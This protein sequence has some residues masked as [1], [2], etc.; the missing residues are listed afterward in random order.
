MN[1]TPEA[2]RHPHQELE[3][4]I[5]EIKAFGNALND[6]VIVTPLIDVVSRI[7]D[8]PEDLTE[9][10]PKDIARIQRE[11][12]DCKRILD[13]FGYEYMKRIITHP[14]QSRVFKILNQANLFE[15]EIR[16]SVGKKI[17]LEDGQTIVMTKELAEALTKYRFSIG[18]PPVTPK[19]IET[20]EQILF[21]GNLQSIYQFRELLG[22][23]KK[24]KA[25]FDA[26]IANV[27]KTVVQSTHYTTADEKRQ[28]EKKATDFNN[29]EGLRGLKKSVV[30]GTA[31]TAIRLIKDE[32][33]SRHSNG[34]HP[35]KVIDQIDKLDDA[36]IA[37]MKKD[38]ET[39]FV[40]KISKV[41]HHIFTSD[42][43]EDKWRGVLGRLILVDDSGNSRRAGTT[44]VYSLNP[45]ITETLDKLHVKD[46]G[47]PANTQMNLRSIIE[48]FSPQG[49]EKLEEKV[50]AKIDDYEKSGALDAPVDELRKKEWFITSQR[51]Y[52]SLTNF[53]RFLQ[54]VKGIKTST[55]GEVLEQSQDLAREIEA[56]AMDYFFKDLKGGKYEVVSVPQGGGRKEIGHV[57]QFQLRKFEAKLADFQSTKLSDLKV[58]LAQL[59]EQR[60]ITASD[61]EAHALQRARLQSRSPLSSIRDAESGSGAMDELKEHL[62]VLKRRGIQEAADVLS[63]LDEALGDA[64]AANLSGQVRALI[65]GKLDGKG[66]GSFAKRM[67]RGRPKAL[68]A[69]VRKGLGL[70]KRAVGNVADGIEEK[71]EA[72]EL[73]TEATDLSFAEKLIND[74]E[75]GSMKPHLALAEVGWTF[76]DVLK[77]DDFPR[78]NYIKIKLKENGEMDADS[79]EE[80]FESARK[81][82]SDFPELF[83]FYCASTTLVINDPHNPTSKVAKNSTKLRLLDIASKYGLTI[84]SDEAYHKQV[85]KSI[86]DEQGDMSLCEFY[87]LNRPRFPKPINIYTTLPTTKWA[88]GGGRRTGVVVTNDKSVSGGE[89]FTEF[90]K[91]N[92]D[93]YNNMS[94]YLDRETYT[95]GIKVKSVCKQLETVLDSASLFLASLMPS[96][97]GLDSSEVIDKIFTEEFA[98]FISTIP[99]LGGPNASEII[100][101]ILSEEFSNISERGFC[102]PLYFALIEARNELDRLQIRGASQLEIVKYISDFISNVKNFRL[103]KQ[104]QRDSAKRSNAANDAIERVAQDYPFLSDK[105]IKPE[106]PFYV[107]V[108]LDDGGADPSLTPFLEAV[109]RARKIDVVPTENGYVRFAFGGEVDG[110]KEGYE[111]LSLAIETDLRI[112]LKYWQQFKEERKRLNQEKDS[113]PELTALKKLFPGGEIELARTLRDKK[114]L[115]DKLAKSKSKGRKKLV[116]DRPANL[117]EIIASIEPDSPAHIVTLNSV[118]CKTPQAMVESPVFRDL[119]NYYLLQIKSKIPELMFLEDNDLVAFYGARQFAQKFQTRIFKNAERE[120]YAKIAYEIAR[121]WFSDSTIKILASEEEDSS[122][123]AIRGSESDLSDYIKAFLKAFLSTED[124]QKLLQSFRK[125]PD[126]KELKPEVREY[127]PIEIGYPSTFQAG[128]KA[129]HGV[130][131]DQSLPKWLQMSINKGEFVANSTATDPSPMLS[132]SGT[133]RVPGV[134]RAILRRDGDGENAPQAEFF[135]GNLEKFAEVMDPKDFVY[136]MVQIGGTKVLLVMSRAYSHY[137]VEELRLFPQTDL[138]PE[139]VANCK[140]DAV[141][142]LGLPTKVMGE[143]YRIGYFMDKNAAG[144]NIPVSWVDTESITDYMGY[145]KK[146]ILTVANEKVKEREMMPIHGSAFT[147]I[148]K[149]GLR[150]TMVMAGD[151]GTGKSETI[152]AMIEQIIKNEGYADQLEGIEFL[153]GDMLSLFEGEDHQL[154]MLGTEQGDFMRMTDIPEDWKERFRDR[155]ANGS[156][157]NLSDPT[158]PRITIGN[159]CDPTKFQ[160]PVRVNAFLNINNFEVPPLSSM[161]ETE[162]PH[163]LLLQEYV[164]GYRGEKG[165]SGDQPNIYASVLKSKK[166]GSQEVLGEYKRDLDLLLGWDILTGASGKAENAYLNFNDVPGGVFRAKSMVKDLFEGKN[167]AM[168]RKVESLTV[169]GTDVKIVYKNGDKEEYSIPSDEPLTLKKS[170]EDAKKGKVSL[171]LTNESGAE[172]GVDI[173]TR[174]PVSIAK[175]TYDVRENHFYAIVKDESGKEEKVIIDREGVFNKIY[176]PIASTYCGNPFV[177]PEGMA[178]VL[179]RFAEVMEKA[180]VITGTLYT[181]LKVAGMEF[182]GPAKASQDLIK[183]LMTDERVNKRFLG[184][185]KK[186]DEA[187]R[188][189]YGAAVLST[190]TIPEAIMAHNLFLIERHESDNVRPVDSKGKVINLKTPHYQCKENIERKAF[191]PSLITPEIAGIISDVCNDPQNDTFSLGDFE[192][193]LDRYAHIQAY[194]SKEELIYQILISNGPAQLNYKETNIAQIPKKEVKKAQKIAEAMMQEDQEKAEK[195]KVA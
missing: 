132:T 121:I 110:S 66:L 33:F 14:E 47:T 184:F 74:I 75:K 167:F 95:M 122:S 106:G 17:T 49:L 148:F 124:Q 128:Y 159:L 119:F 186:A 188:N 99:S 93:S 13:D 91:S 88:E 94:L 105:A 78:S 32:L 152:I 60:Q 96:F 69:L 58:R 77:E 151:S 161:Q 116:F 171:T 157:T 38:K 30:T 31:K 40:V 143:D 163:N 130:H 166:A 62:R 179:T 37:E 173:P 178:A 170:E 97:K 164:D 26:F 138:T 100:D 56:L 54:F 141:S 112:L 79:L 154:Y 114:V 48:N 127:L 160:V 111:N 82:L 29:L 4:Q 139:D 1:A 65:S 20:L 45:T 42:K 53:L 73:K 28:F 80:Q 135:S 84:L 120:V 168:D 16:K 11:V 92:T 187:L 129:V 195:R 25:L 21:G 145:L 115:T 52:L 39:V 150:K 172:V 136:K 158:N 63:G 193:H 83:E 50:K 103:D 162:N 177:S 156:K 102:A 101:Q 41:P 57:G 68:G 46:S 104:T 44:F 180:G 89:T 9:L 70:V 81:A 176:S 107:C 185:I 194:D 64:T 182:D 7:I 125:T 165:T 43:L 24:D 109:A 140:P 133:A 3:R 131:A 51:D 22:G 123:K 126:G 59:K 146:P 18:T 113:N 149:N 86:K 117:A 71:L 34:S 192:Y 174:K 142:Y 5:N 183:F 2:L 134:D 147:M 8:L 23:S 190:N 72:A 108:K 36:L 90:V 35:V 155:I 153:S 137:M 10:D 76:N 144:E 98:G 85:K 118:E 175:T 61:A 15:K 67:E 87:E 55:E 6:E 181:Q 169:E 19:G 191:S 189:K 27:E 12:D